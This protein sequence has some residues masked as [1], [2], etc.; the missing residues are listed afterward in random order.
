MKQYNVEGRVV[1]SENCILLYMHCKL[2]LEELQSDDALGDVSPM[3]YSR[4]QAGWTKEGLQVWCNRHECNVVH[5]D[6]EGLRHPANVGRAPPA[7]Q[8][9]R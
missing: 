2:C 7:L 4:T 3:E 8:D 6:F 9:G 1:S 5:I